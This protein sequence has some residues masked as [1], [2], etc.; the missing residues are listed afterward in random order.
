MKYLNVTNEMFLFLSDDN[1]NIIKWYVNAEFSVHPYFKSPTRTIMN[2]L[3]GAV[4][5]IYNKKPLIQESAYKHS[6]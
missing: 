4:V 6:Q 1:T 5:S 2:I 3:K